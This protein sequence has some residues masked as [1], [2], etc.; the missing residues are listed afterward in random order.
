MDLK[1][2]I[3]LLLFPATAF[4]QFGYDDTWSR[5]PHTQAI[6]LVKQATDRNLCEQAAVDYINSFHQ[7]PAAF[8]PA[9]AA[10][11]AGVIQWYSKGPSHCDGK[12]QFTSPDPP[13]MQ[14]W[15]I[16][17]NPGTWANGLPTQWQI[18]PFAEPAGTIPPPVVTPPP[19][20]EPPPI[21]SVDFQAALNKAVADITAAIQADGDKTRAKV[22]NPGWFSKAVSNPYVQ[23]VL[24]AI[25]TCASTQCWRAK[26]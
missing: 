22:D 5:Y 18:H 3:L 13:F 25:G 16:R 7:V 4:A 21:P 24:V 8:V 23:G 20:P 26:Q 12:F 15:E 2:F 10:L 17:F 1:P 11:P 14:G 6:E 19:V 9:G